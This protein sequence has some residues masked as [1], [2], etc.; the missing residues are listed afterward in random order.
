ML[1]MEN[2]HYKLKYWNRLRS[3]ELCSQLCSVFN[4]SKELIRLLSVTEIQFV[5]EIELGLWNLLIEFFLWVSQVSQLESNYLTNRLQIVSYNLEVDRNSDRPFDEHSENSNILS[6]Q[7]FENSNILLP[8]KLHQI[9]FLT[10]LVEMICGRSSIEVHGSFSKPFGGEWFQVEIVS[11][12]SNRN[13][14]GMRTSSVSA[15]TIHWAVSIMSAHN[16]SLIYSSL[17]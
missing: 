15:D 7:S 4:R 5:Y 3:D 10:K 8:F 2:L 11:K 9:I 14:F 1:S 16:M 6:V 17:Q 12:L 13:C